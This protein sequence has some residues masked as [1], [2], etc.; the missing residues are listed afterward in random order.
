LNQDDFLLSEFK[1]ALLKN[2]LNPVINLDEKFPHKIDLF[3]QIYETIIDKV[4]NR[5]PPHKWSQYRIGLIKQGSA[6]Y[7]CGIY[8]FKLK[9][10]T[11][12]IIPPRIVNSSSN[13]ADDSKGYFLLFNLDFFLQSNFPYH[14]LENKK[15]LQPSVQPYMQLT[16]KQAE[17]VEQIFMTILEEKQGNNPHK[18]E[19]IA[20]KIIELLIL[21]E[22]LYSEVHQ[23]DNN[24]VA[25]DLVKKFTNLVEANFD[26]E[27]SVSF[28]ASELYVHPNYLN[29]IVKRQSG[30][31]AKD[32][33]Q[34]RLL[35]EA[36]Y[37]LHS[38][39]LSVKEISHQLG[40]TDP[41]YFGVFFKRVEGHSPIAYRAP[42]L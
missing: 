7:T 19:L 29:A 36:K 42:M 35:L 20:L 31:T 13:W 15:I 16:T 18:R 12:L 10:N 22:R 11:L 25:L 4:G 1:K 17:A 8:K 34:N 33:I 32:S 30:M 38:T 39:R 2:A 21:I 5:V 26:K 37:L 3:A 28:Y 23:F 9:E 27:K 14:H 41:N 24:E 40:F 6:D